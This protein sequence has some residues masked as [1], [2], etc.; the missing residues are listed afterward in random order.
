MV[1]CSTSGFS[2]LSGLFGSHPRCK[3]AYM[4]NRQQESEIVSGLESVMA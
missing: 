4:Q 1:F 3:L 2:L